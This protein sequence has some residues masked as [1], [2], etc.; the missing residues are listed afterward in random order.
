MTQ[1]QPS[2]LEDLLGRLD[3]EA[4]Y[5]FEERAGIMEYDGGADRDEAE[6]LALADLLRSH[7]GAL[8][9]LR[10]L[11]LE[12]EDEQYLVTT[13]VD[14]AWERAGQGTR[15]HD[16]EDPAAVLRERFD[17]VAA[18]AAWLRPVASTNQPEKE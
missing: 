13:D 15:M 4:R 7:P 14:A 10:F 3:P 1:Q 16:V 2:K 18:L 12:G 5:L 6:L 8:L 17:G 11:R 9:G